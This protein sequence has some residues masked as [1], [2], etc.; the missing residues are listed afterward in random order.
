M[1]EIPYLYLYLKDLKILNANAL[2]N[3]YIAGL[4][5]LTGFVGYSHV[6]ERFLRQ[7]LSPLI[8]LKG[9]APIIH[10]MQL[11]DS[12]PKYVSYK[13]DMDS[14]KQASTIDERTVY[15]G[16]DLLFRLQ[17]DSTPVREQLAE[18]IHCETFAAFLSSLALCGGK[19]VW[20]SNHMELIPQDRLYNQ[21][22]QMPS[23]SFFI[24]D[25]TELLNRD[26][27]LE[28]SDNLDILLD[29]IKR[30]RSIKDNATQS[31]DQPKTFKKSPYFYIPVAIGYH[32]LED[33]PKQRIGARSRKHI[34]AEPV[35]GLAR[36]RTVA[37]VRKQRE[38]LPPIFWH[39]TTDLNQ[40]LYLVRAQKEH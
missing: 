8:K 5:A 18:W 20:L 3:A 39:Y 12:H 19:V 17:I 6:I 1:N 4:P 11:G 25:S 37:S 21:L 36:A 7:Q 10:E 23:Q 26:H 33:T 40:R 27:F 30:R 35:I 38:Q 15:L 22:Q 28:Y 34:Y 13:Q 9:I 16:C 32:G 2:A 29:L 14:H 31:N 24:E